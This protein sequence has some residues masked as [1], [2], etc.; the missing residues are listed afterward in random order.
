MSAQSRLGQDRFA[1]ANRSDN[2]YAELLIEP[3][4]DGGSLLKE[5]KEE[6]DG[7]EED[8]ATSA[9][10]STSHC[11]FC[12]WLSEKRRWF[13]RGDKAWCVRSLVA[14][15]HFGCDVKFEVGTK[16]WWSSVYRW[17]VLRCR[18]TTFCACFSFC[19]HSR[20]G[21]CKS[22]HSVLAHRSGTTGRCKLSLSCKLPDV[23]CEGG[24]IQSSLFSGSPTS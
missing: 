3:D 10:S 1:H 15:V 12:V 24:Q 20:G 19:P 9:A 13:V 6:I 23:S 21:P 11:E 16:G 22:S 8:P 14:F 5:S 18:K 7:R 2:S 17:S 4:L